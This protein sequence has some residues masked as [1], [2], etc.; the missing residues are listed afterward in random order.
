MHSGGLGLG[1]LTFV[2][3]YSYNLIFTSNLHEFRRENNP[4]QDIM[5]RNQE[6]NTQCWPDGPQICKVVQNQQ[7][8]VK[9]GDILNGPGTQMDTSHILGALAPN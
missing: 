6:L 7:P 2:C 4:P 1:S 3:I 9:I 8:E 5:S